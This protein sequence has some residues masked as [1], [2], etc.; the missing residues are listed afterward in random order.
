MN[1]PHLNR[2]HLTFICPR[3]ISFKR[4]FIDS[5]STKSFTKKR[6]PRTINQ[7][8]N[9][10]HMNPPQSTIK[11]SLTQISFKLNSELVLLDDEHKSN[12]FIQPATE[13]GTASNLPS[14]G[15]TNCDKQSR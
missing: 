4:S 9:L 1:A 3:N 12:D 6:H 11:P 8:L 15:T 14:D 13:Y 5:Q 7:C 2:I 10:T